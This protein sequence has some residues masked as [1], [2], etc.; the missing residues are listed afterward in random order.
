MGHRHLSAHGMETRTR[1]MG[2]GEVG[3]GCDRRVECDIRTRP[4][5]QQKIDAGSVLGGGAFAGR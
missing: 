5:G 3:V 2:E 4:G 1:G